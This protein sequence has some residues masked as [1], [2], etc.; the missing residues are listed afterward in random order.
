MT[1]LKIPEEGN[2]AYIQGQTTTQKTRVNVIGNQ[3]VWYN[4]R[5]AHQYHSKE[6]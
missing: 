4:G 1:F 3:R 2:L 6:G 5:D